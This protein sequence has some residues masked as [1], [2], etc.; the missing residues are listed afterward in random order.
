M[1]VSKQLLSDHFLW[2]PFQPKYGSLPKQVA[3]PQP[4]PTPNQPPTSNVSP[5]VKE[6]VAADEAVAA[7]SAAKSEA[8]K[9]E[10]EADLDEAIG[11][12]WQL[13][14]CR[15]QLLGDDVL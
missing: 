5:Q 7:E 3:N 10:V 13:M 2:Y 8:Q 6:S 14:T 12:A 1:R 4:Q 11:W 9:A 15:W